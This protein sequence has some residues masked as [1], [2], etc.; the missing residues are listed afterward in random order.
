MPERV[1]LEAATLLYAGAC[2]F[3]LAYL[4]EKDERLSAWMLR[5]AA[6]AVALHGISFI[7]RLQGFWVFAEN[8]FLLPINSMSGALSFF[9][10]CAALVFFL[11]ERE[12]RLGI[13]GAFILP[14]VVLACAAATLGGDFAFAAL[15]PKMR[16]AW[17]NWHPAL[18]MAAYALFGN[19]FGVGVALLVQERQL[20]SRHPG[21]LCF[22]LPS[23]EELDRL[24]AALISYG[25]PILAAGLGGGIVWAHGAWQKQ[26]AGDPKVV[27]ALGTACLYALFLYLRRSRGLSGR[28]AVYLSMAGFAS[29]IFTFVVA[30][31]LTRLH[32]YL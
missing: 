24:N 17:L 31:L 26:W 21:A 27:S 16:S 11:V 22:R 20:K 2:A 19:A 25:L 9:A 10:F 32:G 14:G 4:Y 30:S 5:L 13:L 12:H 28:R 29:V 7:V 15:E 18:L 3:A 8:R 23:L 6:A 1:L